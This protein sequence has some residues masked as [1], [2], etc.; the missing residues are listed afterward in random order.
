LKTILLIGAGKSATVLIQ[1]LIKESEANNWKFLVADANIQQVLAKTG[2]SKFATPIALDVT[3][4]DARE[5]LIQKAHVVISM[6]PPDLHFLI[7]KDCVEYRK[8]LLTASYLDDKMTSLKDEIHHRKL[9]FLCEMG[10]DP[11]IDHM[12]AMQIIHQ[13]KKQG[14]IIQSFKSHCGGLIAPESDNN[15][16][17]YKISWNP[18]N[19]VMAG[20]AGAVYKQDGAT[21]KVPYQQ[22]FAARHE[23]K[24]EGLDQLAWYP[25]RDSLSYIPIYKLPEANTF[26]RTT[27]RHPQYLKGWQALVEANLTNDTILIQNQQLSIKEWSAPILPFLNDNN[28]EM[29]EY[30]GLFTADLIPTSAKSNADVLQHLLESKLMMLPTDKDMIVMLHEID[31]ELNGV[32]SSIH[33]SLVVKGENNIAT[34]MAKTVGLPLGIAAKLLLNGDLKL[35]GLHIPI[36]PEIYEPVLQSLE[37]EG[38]AF[39]EKHI[40]A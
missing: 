1:Y 21:V 7:A 11:G 27:L 33:S 9:L 26:I 15:P 29:L 24:V 20:N 17:H 3:D 6:M 19:V 12:S 28:R 14:A 22:I 2:N 40:T 16:W 32:A 39:V 30:L 36:S 13:L 35:R 34:A 8:H 18:R 37:E 23:V 4:E 31:F 25:N 5:K 38:I 10:L